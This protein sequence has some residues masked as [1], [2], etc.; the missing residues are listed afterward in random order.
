MNQNQ[1]NSCE[2]CGK[3]FT[4][5]FQLGPHK[6]FCWNQLNGD[7]CDQFTDDEFEPTIEQP[8]IEQP[9]IEQPAATQ[10]PISLRALAS[11]EPGT[12]DT[13]VV[14]DFVVVN[15]QFNQH[16]PVLTHDYTQV[17]SIRTCLTLTPLKPECG[18]SEPQM[19][20]FRTPNK[21]FIK[22]QMRVFRTPNAG[23]QNPKYGFSKPQMRG[24]SNPKCGFC[25]AQMRVL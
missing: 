17:S 8:T 25:K 18:F 3:G 10:Q 14:S 24:F 4:N 19:L 15:P 11:R 7:C 22:A 12:N 5:A 6:R 21:G 16:N 1:E 23:F 2:Y 9:T 20:V 13:S